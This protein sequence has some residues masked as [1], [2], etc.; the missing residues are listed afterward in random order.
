MFRAS[1]S[2]RARMASRTAT[3]PGY[4][5]EVVDLVLAGGTVVDG[6]GSTGF[7]G[8]VGVGG[9]RIL[10]VA[11]EGEPEPEA[12]SRID[13]GGRAIVPG[14][15][16]VHTHS[17]LSPLVDP[18][19]PSALRQGVTTVVV[20]NC[21]A[22]PWPLAGFAEALDDAGGDPSTTPTP[23]WRSFGDYLDALQ[24][25]QPGINIA[26]LVGHGAIRGEVLGHERRP[27][28][29]QELT[30]MRRSVAE[31]MDSGAL[32]LSTGLIYV[33]G[34]FSDTDEIVA[35]AEEAA[36]AGGIYAS[37]IRGEGEH[38][39]TAVAEAL[40]V[41]RRAALPAH[42]SHLKCES[43]MLHGQSEELLSLIHGAE[44]VTADQYPYEA[45]NS[46]LSSLLPPWAPVGTIASVASDPATLERLRSAVEQ[47]E[48]DFQS[49]V[50]GVGWDR[51]V[52]VGTADPKWNGR[53][54]ASLASEMEVEPILAVVRLLTDGPMTSCTGH[55]MDEAD[56]R[57]ILSDADI[58]VASD[59]TAISPDGPTGHLPVHPRA[60][61]TFPRAIALCRDENLLH[62]ESVIRK[63]TSL[64]AERFGLADRGRIEEGA[65]ADL[66]V[67]DPATVRDTAT[68]E[69]PHSY[70]EGI[71]S[72]LVNG[73]LAWGGVNPLANRSGRVLRKT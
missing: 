61:G 43:S 28:T 9:D 38:L 67:L 7:A 22:S 49:S 41:G 60:Y 17:D 42:V 21:G 59:A 19:M 62:F 50:K 4:H 53:D 47:G 52:V 71:D 40:H 73:R 57:R 68:Y 70:P 63:M 1:Y 51:I 13:I 58:F 56:V 10:R 64:P 48:P 25:T 54:I 32:G 16:D 44:N 5:P 23:E 26:A 30:R 6:S 46:Y 29:L 39:F 20:G 18:W 35:L 2:F 27:P 15:I 37:H 3:L 24:A 45:W 65:F 69:N 14:F 11:R 33:P 66:V 72:V 8:W 31:A 36:V 12:G 55:A 34:M